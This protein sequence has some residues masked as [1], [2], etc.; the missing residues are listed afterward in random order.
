M[1]TGIRLPLGWAVAAAGVLFDRWGMSPSTCSIAGSVR[2]RC[3]EVGDLDIL[4][5][6]P[7]AAVRDELFAAIDKTVIVKDAESR[8]CFTAAEFDPFVE[9]KSGHKPYFKSLSVIAH[10]EATGEDGK[11]RTFPI[12][13]QVNRY[14]KANRGWMELY[15]T[16]PTEFGVW[17]L[18][19]WKERFGIPTHQKACIEN[20]LRDQ[21]GSIVP[22]ETEADCFRLAGLTHFPPQDREEIARRG[23]AGWSQEQRERMS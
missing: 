10:L 4:A 22:V 15:K 21:G 9:V 12:P 2:R 5:P 3:Q 1:S 8:L 17:F 19:K 18:V 14:T 23:M 20:H 6:L 16:G 13:V 11:P 7:P